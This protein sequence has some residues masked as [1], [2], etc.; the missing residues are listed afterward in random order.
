LGIGN[1]LSSDKQTGELSGKDLIFFADEF[2]I[3]VMEVVCNV[4]AVVV[5]FALFI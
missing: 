1:P 4:D 3:L 5:L 2:P